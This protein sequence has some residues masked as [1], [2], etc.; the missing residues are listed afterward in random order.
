ML[1]QSIVLL[2][3][4][5]L[6][7]ERDSIIEDIIWKS[8]IQ[9]SY[10]PNTTNPN[11]KYST[12]RIFSPLE[13]RSLN[14]K[15]L[16]NYENLPP[17]E[18]QKLRG[19]LVESLFFAEPVPGDTSHNRDKPKTDITKADEA[20]A[21]STPAA[22]IGYL[23]VLHTFLNYKAWLLWAAGDRS[24]VALQ[25]SLL[26]R[27]ESKLLY[28]KING[29]SYEALPHCRFF[30]SP[31]ATADHLPAPISGLKPS[32]LELYL[33]L[34][35]TKNSLNTL[36]ELAAYGFNLVPKVKTVQIGGQQAYLILEHGNLPT[37]GFAA[38][39]TRHEKIQHLLPFRFVSQIYVI[40]KNETKQA[41]V[42][43]QNIS[44][45][46]AD[47]NPNTSPGTPV[48]DTPPKGLASINLDSLISLKE[49]LPHTQLASDPPAESLEKTRHV[50]TIAIVERSR[51]L[52]ILNQGNGD[53]AQPLHD[54]KSDSSTG[55]LQLNC[56][57]HPFL[58]P[59]SFQRTSHLWRPL[60][61]LNEKTREERRLEEQEIRQKIKNLPKQ[62]IF[63]HL[64]GLKA[65]NAKGDLY[66]KTGKVGKR[67]KHSNN[68]HRG[69]AAGRTKPNQKVSEETWFPGRG[70]LNAPTWVIGLYPSTSEI[71]S[72]PPTIFVGPSGIELTNQLKEG[73][74]R[75]EHRH[76]PGQYPAQIRAAGY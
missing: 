68:G 71:E 67:G 26:Q 5:S 51:E 1:A 48:P 15:L 66:S 33:E 59:A 36:R 42:S 43:Q 8:E 44:L 70:N 7:P 17:E 54:T 20:P 12:G 14:A 35:P 45:A 4:Y 28:Q 64:R 16:P 21:T 60:Q 3:N 39:K 34:H 27:P 11:R 30:P 58:P 29:T 25:K 32:T 23:E 69:N 9:I 10:L 57:D 65:W 50:P 55:H 47:S 41:N 24:P 38:A 62:Q 73:G 31:V 75:R 72:E 18:I 37:Q 46:D 6:N 76:L 53:L 2:T 56:P 52:W 74:Y 49:I 22:W 19:S 63:D 40:D 13:L 61:Q